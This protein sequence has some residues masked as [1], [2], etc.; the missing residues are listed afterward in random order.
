MKKLLIACL[1]LLLIFNSIGFQAINATEVDP[2]NEETYEPSFPTEETNSDDSIKENTDTS[3]S[4]EEETNVDN[5]END[6]SSN[7]TYE[8][9]LYLDEGEFQNAINN[10]VP[11][12]TYYNLYFGNVN[13]YDVSSYT[14]NKT[15]TNNYK[16]YVNE[17]DSLD[18][19]V[20][21][22]SG[23]KV[24]F[25]SYSSNF[26]S[27]LNYS[28]YIS[29]ISFK[30]IDT[31]YV[32][33]MSGMF[34]SC[35]S[36]T[37][38]DVS[39]FDTSNVTNMS[40]MFEYCSSLTFL[41]V[42]SFNTSNVIKMYEIF[43]YCSSLTTID[44]SS[45]DI[46]NVTNMDYMFNNCSALTT[47]YSTSNFDASSVKFNDYMFSDCPKLVG[48]SGT[49]FNSSKVNG[50]YAHIDGG[51]DN[52][53]YFTNKNNLPSKPVLSVDNTYTYTGSEQTVEVTGFD[54]T[55]MDIE[56]NKATVA[57]NYTVTVKPKT[58][59]AD[60]TTDPVTIEWSIGKA[61]PSY[62]LPTGLNATQGGKLSDVTL[63]EGWKW[64]APETQ[65]TDAGSYIYTATF[66]PEDTKNYNILTN[67]T[68]TVEIIPYTIEFLD[69]EKFKN[70]LS[71][72][73][74]NLYF[75]TESDYDLSKCT[76]TI[77]LGNNYTLYTYQD[78]NTYDGYVI[79]E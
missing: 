23:K 61:D 44:I 55:T 77:N 3:V 33:D 12:R 57:G 59:W 24:V 68:V 20:L 37:A 22:E 19:Y 62:T 10:I 9:I 63:P 30:N 17:R 60:G 26:F 79:C 36:L 71:F 46:S 21:A 43:Q 72:D 13:D 56:G 73:V 27:H 18:I 39:N 76:Q 42:S 7:I 29:N 50:T 38:L 41:N 67:I 47:I 45:F 35:S 8:E 66:T 74:T 70:N 31:S 25:P 78:D 58:Q 54:D 65:L 75:G 48:G 32:T 15:L 28:Y 64:N 40:F 34:S 52:P 16:V 51:T 14:L 5:A 53:G 69:K 6:N 2:P 1:N 4:T 11:T 49:K